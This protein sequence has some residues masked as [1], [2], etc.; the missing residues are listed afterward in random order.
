MSMIK[1]HSKRDANKTV[2]TRWGAVTF[3]ADGT[4]EHNIP[5][6]DVALLNQLNWTADPDA[7]RE[8]AHAA[9]KAA[10]DAKT[11]PAVDPTH[12]SVIVAHDKSG[13]KT[14]KTRWGAIVFDKD[15]VA[16]VKM[17]EAD[18]ALVAQLGW[19]VVASDAAVPSEPPPG[20][21]GDEGDDGDKKKKKKSRN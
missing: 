6:A 9:L 3:G 12:V 16:E 19:S 21:D 15:G 14:V 7:I 5:D 8:A 1:L 11:A 20:D 2:K 17:P 18:M 13:G 10:E 4:A